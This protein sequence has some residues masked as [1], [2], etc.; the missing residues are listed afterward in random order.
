[1][2]K[3]TVI[4][5]VYGVEKYIERCARS[6]FEQTLDDMEFVFVDDCTK[7]NSIWVLE[8]VI[9][10]YPNRK[11]QIKIL[12]HEHNK[13]LSHARE[14]GVN[15]AVGEYIAHC[16]SDDWVEHNMYE[17]LYNEAK[18]LDTDI[19]KC[20]FYISSN[21]DTVI[22]INHSNNILQQR[23]VLSLLYSW[24]GWNQIWVLLVKKNLYNNVVFTDNTMMEDFFVVAQLYAKCQNVGVYNKPLYYYFQNLNSICGRTSDKAIIQRGLQAYENVKNILSLLRPNLTEPYSKEIVRLKYEA[25]SR[26]IPSL[27]SF[28]NFKYF[29]L[30][31]PE[32]RYAVFFNPYIH[33]KEKIQYILVIIRIYP[34]IKYFKNILICG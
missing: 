26:I 20:G 15:A 23:E 22:P 4:V 33:I 9:E 16:D 29:N 30:I 14:T 25:Q 3:V 21:T 34:I 5:P 31:F 13:G 17:E 6:L 8:R 11:E 24:K 1:M 10:D 7:D 32:I 27:H 19:V 18:K 2:P 12:H 28:A